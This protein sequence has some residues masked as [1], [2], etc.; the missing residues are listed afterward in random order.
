[1]QQIE[2]EMKKVNKNYSLANI[3]LGR[4]TG[5]NS[6]N[7]LVITFYTTAAKSKT[8]TIGL[9]LNTSRTDF[10]QMSIEADDEAAMDGNLTSIAAR[11]NAGTLMKQLAATLDG[12]YM[13]TPNN[14]FNPTGCELQKIEVVEG[15]IRYLDTKYVLKQ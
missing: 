13:I 15:K 4:S 7:G 11:T 1:M 9:E 14:Y 5:K 3:G 8:N 6:V 10:G 2:T 12:L